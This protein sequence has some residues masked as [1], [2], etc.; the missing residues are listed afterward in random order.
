[1]R[2]TF[3]LSWYTFF[4][5]TLLKADVCRLNVS[6]NDKIDSMRQI[7]FHIAFFKIVGNEFCEN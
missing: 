2:C 3:L 4:T 5:D 7:M 1:M 6:F